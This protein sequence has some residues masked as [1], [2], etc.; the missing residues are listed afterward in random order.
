MDIAV[1]IHGL[2]YLLAEHCALV[3]EAEPSF[4]QSS[5]NAYSMSRYLSEHL[6]CTLSFIGALL[7]T[8][9]RA[10]FAIPP[11]RAVRGG[12]PFLVFSIRMLCT[13]TPHCCWAAF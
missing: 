6:N 9:L 13:L 5:R 4:Q 8:S 10:G 2:C 11:W 12:G 1:A 7:A 3:V